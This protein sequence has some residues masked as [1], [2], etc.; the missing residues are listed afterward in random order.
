MDDT[1]FQSEAIKSDTYFQSE[2]SGDTQGCDACIQ[3]PL[4]ALN[5]CLAI[6]VIVLSLT[7]TQWL[8]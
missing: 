7:H 5:H 2:A 4:I 1:Y 8:H 6:A 3:A